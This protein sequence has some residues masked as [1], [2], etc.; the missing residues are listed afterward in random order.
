MTDSWDQ[1]DASTDT[2]SN[3]SLSGT[4]IGISLA[5]AE[6]KAYFAGVQKGPIG[7]LRARFEQDV[8]SNG[9]RNLRSGVEKAL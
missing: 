6:P 9:R 4:R 2:W 8:T 1:Y 3:G 7:D 5:Q